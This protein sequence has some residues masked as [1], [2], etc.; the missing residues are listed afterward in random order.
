MEA[1][2]RP[3]Y[4]QVLVVRAGAG[5]VARVERMLC[6]QLDRLQGSD[7]GSRGEVGTGARAYGSSAM[8]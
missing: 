3:V 5:T 6:H 2:S 7:R 1:D 8:R 4:R